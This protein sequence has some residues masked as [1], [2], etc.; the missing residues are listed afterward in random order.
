MVNRRGSCSLKVLAFGGSSSGAEVVADG[1]VDP[2]QWYWPTVNQIR[3]GGSGQ[4]GSSSDA[5]VVADADAAPV[6]M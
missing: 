2:M 1:E 5:E 4:R 3:C 6:R